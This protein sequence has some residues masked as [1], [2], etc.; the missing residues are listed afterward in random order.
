MQGDIVFRSLAL[1][2]EDLF[3]NEAPTTWLFLREAAQARL[4]H[5]RCKLIE[6]LASNNPG[7]LSFGFQKSR[8]Y[9]TVM[10][11]EL[12]RMMEE[13]VLDLVRRD[14]M[15]RMPAPPDGEKFSFPMPPVVVKGGELSCPSEDGEDDPDLGMTQVVGA[16]ALYAAL[17]AASVLL[18]LGE[19]LGAKCQPR[20]G[21]GGEDGFDE[22]C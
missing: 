19:A 6:S 10:N 16:F 11:F 22:R 3:S 15:V 7:L 12:L 21:R 14:H 20:R 4:P 8:P 18:L 1:L 5:Y 2:L 13:G 9:R 17:A